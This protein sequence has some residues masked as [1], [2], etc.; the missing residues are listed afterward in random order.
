M[1]TLGLELDRR[2]HIQT[3]S[4]QYKRRAGDTSAE[5]VELSTPRYI[6][7]W[8]ALGL[9]PFCSNSAIFQPLLSSYTEEKSKLSMKPNLSSLRIRDDLN[10]LLGFLLYEPTN[11]E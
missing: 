6:I 1:T 7:A 8:C 3:I 4:N 5:H 2:R 11:G 9:P 10:R